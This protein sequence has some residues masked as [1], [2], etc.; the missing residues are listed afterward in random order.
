[1]RMVVVRH[2]IPFSVMPAKA[3]IHRSCAV[4]I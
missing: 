4:R 2:L 1:M 3:G